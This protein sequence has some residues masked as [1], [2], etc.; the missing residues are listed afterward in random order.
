M[1]QKK[2][3]GSNSQVTENQHRQSSE[4]DGLMPEFLGRH[5]KL[6]SSFKLVGGQKQ[7]DLR[8]VLLTRCVSP[9]TFALIT[10]LMDVIC[11]PR[12]K[13][14]CLLVHCVYTLMNWM[15]NSWL[16]N[17]GVGYRWFRCIFSSCHVQS[18]LWTIF[19][20]FCKF[21]ISNPKCTNFYIKL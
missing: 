4:K 16:Y 11:N 12:P 5:S 18:A 3:G 14:L 19:A 6:E 2:L 9:T 7:T 8:Q 21:K 10:D 13:G 17:I 1:S 15:K 20:P